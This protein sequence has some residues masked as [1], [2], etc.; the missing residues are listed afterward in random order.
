MIERARVFHRRLA[1]DETP[2]EIAANTIRP[3]LVLLGDNLRRFAMVPERER[4]RASLGD[5]DAGVERR[6]A[7]VELPQAQ[8][9]RAQGA[10]GQ[11]DLVGFRIARGKLYELVRQLQGLIELRPVEDGT[12]VQIAIGVK[13]GGLT[14]RERHALSL[15]A[16]QAGRTRAR[17]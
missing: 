10:L 2:I 15:S 7:F 4:E 9:C 14:R 12:D 17:P 5:L 1:E 6:A 3:P 16:A 13:A 11:R 8:Q